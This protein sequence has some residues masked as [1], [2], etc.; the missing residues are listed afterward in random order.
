MMTQWQLMRNLDKQKELLQQRKGQSEG[1]IKAARNSLVSKLI[2]KLA[3]HLHLIWS[4]YLSCK[5]S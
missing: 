2:L 3:Q 4:S 5:A 1:W